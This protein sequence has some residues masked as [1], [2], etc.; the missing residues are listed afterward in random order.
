M[1]KTH[2]QD[3]YYAHLKTDNDG[4]SDGGKKPLK[5]KIKAK[6]PQ[7]SEE[8]ADTHVEAP[9]S[10]VIREEEKPKARLIAREPIVARPVQKKE[11]P[12]VQQPKQ[13][14][15]TDEKKKV[16]VFDRPQTHSNEP[17]KKF[18]PMISFKKAESQ[19]KVL[20]N[21]PVMKVQG[22]NGYN[23]PSS[24]GNQSHHNQDDKKRLRDDSKPIFQ[25]EIAF[26]TPVKDGTAKK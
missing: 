10:A 23:K 9:V 6:K 5:L 24:N 17:K 16:S 2:E 25:R 13:H 14:H 1:T 8:G 19:V 12:V 21:R 26:G 3:D 18:T 4:S 22:Q 11:T 15:T 7:D 20:E